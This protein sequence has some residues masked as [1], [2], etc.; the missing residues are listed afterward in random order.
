MAG[1]LLEFE[2][3]VLKAQGNGIFLVKLGADAGYVEISCHLSG[4]IKKN[5]IRILEGDR[6]KVSVSPYD[7][8]KGIITFRTKT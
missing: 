4:K 6:V 5:T 2:G 1:D 7:L 8:T 3:A